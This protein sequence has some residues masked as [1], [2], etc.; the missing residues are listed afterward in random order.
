MICHGIG[1]TLLYMSVSFRSF[2]CNRSETFDLAN[3]QTSILDTS[4]VSDA[5]VTDCL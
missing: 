2:K 3:Q 1:E 4:V 5:A